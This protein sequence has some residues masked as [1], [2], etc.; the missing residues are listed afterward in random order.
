MS[1]FSKIFDFL[2]SLFQN[3]DSWIKEHVKPSI[4]FVENI[5]AILESPVADIV[6]ALIP[7]DVDDKIRAFILANCGKA[8]NALAI[9]QDIANEPDP[10]QAIIKLLEYLKTAAPAMKAAIYKQLASEMA[11]L[12]NGGKEIVKGHSVDLLTQLEYSK[13]VVEKAQAAE[14]AQAEQDA[15]SEQPEQ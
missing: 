14:Q 3:V 11:K 4:E 9:T 15:E 7:G 10:V 5:K 12:S 13:M 2:K 6:T 1:I 8:L